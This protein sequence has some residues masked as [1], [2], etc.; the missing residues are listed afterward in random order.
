MGSQRLIPFYRRWGPFI[1]LRN[2]ASGPH[3]GLADTLARCGCLARLFR[4]RGRGLSFSLHEFC[5]FI[6]IEPREKVKGFSGMNSRQELELIREYGVWM[7]SPGIWRP[8][9]QRP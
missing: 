1:L 5:L 3:C 8:F 4:S 9:K 7:K 2:D 6:R